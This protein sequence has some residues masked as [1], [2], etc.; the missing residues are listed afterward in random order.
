MPHLPPPTT[1]LYRSRK[2]RIIAGVC[3]GL[4]DRFHIDPIWV[5]LIFILF[6]L[7]GGSS[8]LIY[9]ILWLIVPLQ[10]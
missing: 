6:F 4:G 10:P 9:L 2:N 7:A 5:R 1:R 8:L 3:G